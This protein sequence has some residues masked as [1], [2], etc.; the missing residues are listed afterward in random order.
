MSVTSLVFS[1]FSRSFPSVALAA[2]LGVALGVAPAAMAA[3]DN[4]DVSVRGNIRPSACRIALS[5]NGEVDYGTISATVVSKS[6][7]GYSPGQREV[8]LT[9]HCELET[10]VGVAVRDNRVG[11]RADIT[12]IDLYGFGLGK[13]NEFKLGAY[14]IT[15]GATAATEKGEVALLISDD[16]GQNWARNSLR[17]LRADGV[18][19]LSW[20]EP[21]STTPAARRQFQ[22]PLR[23]DAY[24]PKADALPKLDQTIELDGSATLSLVYL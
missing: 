6:T 17:T 10:R 12:G 1:P 11:T 3:N 14:T 9:I 4:S 8:V 18:S 23:V 7:A 21:G 22:T 13:F 20:A 19:M 16:K 2:A 15:P 5:E 24:L